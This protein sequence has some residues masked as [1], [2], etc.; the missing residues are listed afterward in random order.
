MPHSTHA[1]NLATYLNE[2]L[3]G[4]VAAVDL[5]KYLIESRQGTSEAGFFDTLRR[6]VIADQDTLKRLLNRFAEESRLQ[7]AAGWV[8]GK[9]VRHKIH[10]RG[11]EMG[12]PGLLEALEI[13]AIG[14]T[15]KRL[16]WTALRAALPDSP[17]LENVDLGDLEERALDQFDRV[18]AARL[19]AARAAFAMEPVSV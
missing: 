11:E 7:S 17:L 12:E 5:M 19:E 6:E 13:L 3:A 16:L 2:H 18:E 14:I 10:A 9:F 1:E 15:G 4:S 8:A